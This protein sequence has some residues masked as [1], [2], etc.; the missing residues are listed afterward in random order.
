MLVNNGYT[1]VTAQQNMPASDS[2]HTAEPDS[3]AKRNVLLKEI[4]IKW[5]KFSEAELSALKN[6]DDLV[7]GVIAKY[8]FEK[9]NAQRDVDALLNGRHI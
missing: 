1:Q 8:S 5:D 2:T 3:T 6:K 7:A 4:Q 9:A